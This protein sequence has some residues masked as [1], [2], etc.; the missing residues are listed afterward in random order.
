MKITKLVHS[1]LLV[2]TPERTTLFDPGV[3]S[4]VDVDGLQKLD[5]VI[6]THTHGDH[7]D[8]ELIKKLVTKF[9]SLH[10]TATDEIVAQLRIES[11]PATSAAS[12]GIAFFEAPHEATQPYY[13]ADPPQEIG[14][15]YL[16]TLSHPGDSH[17]FNETKAVLALPIQAPWGSPNAAVALGLKLRPQCIIPIH[18]WHWSDQ[19]RAAS[20]DE[21][22]KAFG[23]QG[24]AFIKTVN[25]EPFEIDSSH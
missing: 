12:E 21:M 17:S 8:L 3:Y 2:E 24:I 13:E 6:I 5:D 14:V 7:F 25:G 11:I 16:D 20:Y 22:E 23:R 10:I 19:A 15:H 1:C 18:D 9:P 4:T